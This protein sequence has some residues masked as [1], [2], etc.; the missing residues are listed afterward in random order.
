VGRHEG[1]IKFITDRGNVTR[2]EIESY[3][4]QGIGSLIATAV[5]TEFNKIQFLMRTP[6]AYEYDVTLTRNPQ[7][8]HYKLSYIDA[9]NITKELSA[10]SLEALSSAMSRN[11]AEFNQNSIN[12]IRWQ[13]TIIPAVVF[14][15]WKN[16]TPSMV[17]P[18]ELLTRALTNFYITPNETNY[19]VVRGILAR[20][21][22]A[23]FTDGDGFTASML[24][25]MDSTL[26]FFSQELNYKTNMDIS[27]TS[28]MIAAADIP[29]EP[30]YGIFTLTKAAGDEIFVSK[31]NPASA[32]QLTA[33][34]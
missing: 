31:R 25:S 10:T 8:G 14:D 34:Y 1:I 6:T 24:A 16:T 7:T 19:S 17:N 30:Q 5:D 29:D 23:A 20:A 26:R 33:G 11:L 28:K 22:L 18:Y 9:K 12:D 21:Q 4:R 13:A 3:Y 32:R 2:A 15:G 27:T